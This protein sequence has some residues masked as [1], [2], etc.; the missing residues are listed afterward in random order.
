MFDVLFVTTSFVL[1]LKQGLLNNEAELC[2][3]DFQSLVRHIP[4]A[5]QCFTNIVDACYFD[6]PF[7][8][9][10]DLVRGKWASHLGDFLYLDDWPTL[11]RMLIT[12]NQT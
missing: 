1:H 5:G 3:S 9:F 10:C 2:L 8:G 7:D 12:K 11:E 4:L 6:T